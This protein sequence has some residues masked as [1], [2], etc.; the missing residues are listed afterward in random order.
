MHREG[1]NLPSWSTVPNPAARERVA[2][3]DGMKTGDHT[4]CLTTRAVD[5]SLCLCSVLGSSLLWQS[6]F[7]R[8]SFFYEIPGCV[9]EWISNSYSLSWTLFLLFFFFLSNFVLSY[10]IRFPYYRIEAYLLS[11]ERQNGC[12]SRW[13]G[14]CGGTGRSGGKGN[15]NQD[16]L[17][18]KKIYFQ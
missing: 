17:C 14:R 9:K 16:T 15:S 11:S 18:E 3:V 4:D 1:E 7:K 2:E 6:G 13:E 12:G 8:E 10:C 5:F